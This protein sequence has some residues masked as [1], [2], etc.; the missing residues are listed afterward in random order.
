MDAAAKEKL[1]EEFRSYLFEEGAG[2][3]QIEENGTDLYTLLSELI[4]LKNEVKIESRQVKAALEQ[5]K[6]VFDTLQ[7][8]HANLTAE[9]DRLREE[10][11][12][13]EKKSLRPC[14]LQLLELYDRLEAGILAVSNQRPSLLFRFCRREQA[15]F[16]SIRE[17]QEMTMRRLE[18]ILAFYKVHFLAVKGRPL[19]PDRMRG[20]EVDHLDDYEDGVVVAEVRKGFLWQ[21]EVLRPAE[22]RVNRKK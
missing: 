7:A 2:P 3:D 15:F 13:L 17:G 18:Q 20:V 11:R 9:I 4:A 1:L 19:D 12:H 16:T 5:F 6:T 21:D 8:G 10:R 22:V 14:L